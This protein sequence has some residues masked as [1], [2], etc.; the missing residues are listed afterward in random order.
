MAKLTLKTPD[1]P[2]CWNREAGES[3]DYLEFVGA[4]GYCK[5][6]GKEVFTYFQ[7]LD[8]CQELTVEDN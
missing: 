1:G 8:I 2:E 5:I 3:C 4:A 6:F 7:K